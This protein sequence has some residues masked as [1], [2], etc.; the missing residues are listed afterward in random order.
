MYATPVK[1]YYCPSARPPTAYVYSGEAKS[2]YVGNCGNVWAD[3]GGGTVIHT[4]IPWY[5]GYSKFP[6][7]TLVT[8]TDG[9][10]N[11]LL[12]GEKWLHP[13]QQG[14]DGGD[15]EPFVNAGWDEDH[16]RARAAPTA[17]S[18]ALGRRQAPLSRS[19]TFL[20]RTSMRR[21]PRAARPFGMN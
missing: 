19:I 12:V 17:A 13:N 14:K 20:V 21:T 8:I 7:V 4:N 15:N 10:S 6:T 2:D 18:I 11:T 9:T 16:V 1:T 5:S 3:D